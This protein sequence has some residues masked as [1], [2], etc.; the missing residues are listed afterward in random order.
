M[1]EVCHCF[2]KDRGHLV[3]RDMSIVPIYTVFR[4]AVRPHAVRTQKLKSHENIIASDRQFLN[5]GLILR[6]A[7]LLVIYGNLHS[8]IRV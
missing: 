2:V 7:K 4:V 6:S 3:V 1:C 5:D 8:Y